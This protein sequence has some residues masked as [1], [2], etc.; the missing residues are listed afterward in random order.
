MKDI[1]MLRH[2]VTKTDPNI[3]VMCENRYTLKGLEK[4]QIIKSTVMVELEDGERGRIKKI[5]DRWGGA[6]PEG[7]AMEVS[8]TL[9]RDW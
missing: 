6:L 5:E 4:E 9:G 7:K 2:K 8:E 1:K 3:E